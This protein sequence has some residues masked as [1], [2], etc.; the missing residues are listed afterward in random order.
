MANH[1]QAIKRHKQS[2]LRR[3]RNKFFMSTMRT[4]IKRALI[5]FTDEKLADKKEDAAKAVKTACDYIQKVSGKGMIHR[6]KSSRM[7][8]RITKKFNTK[9]GI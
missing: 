4:N 6:N 7:V 2:L 5:Y 8:S 9:F 1:K 3:D